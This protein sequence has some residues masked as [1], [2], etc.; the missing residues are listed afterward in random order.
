MSSVLRNWRSPI[1]L[2]AAVVL[3]ALSA[4]ACSQGPS[5]QTISESVDINAAPDKVWEVIGDFQ[6]FSWH[7]A[8]EK[9]EGNGGNSAGATRKVTLGGGGTID[10]KLTKHSAD[11]KSFSYVITDVDV[12]VLPVK[13]YSSTLSV[14]DKD[15]KSVVTW[16]GTFKRGDL[17]ANPPPELNDE[18]AVKTMTGVY[19]A[20][21]EAVKSSVEG[22]S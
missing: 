21:L 7:P 12:K 4:A 16:S 14:K 18:A 10:E 5:E 13:D 15:G 11:D 20:G 3:V 17:S 2:C 1:G 9:T 6:D 8:V 22:S 19:K